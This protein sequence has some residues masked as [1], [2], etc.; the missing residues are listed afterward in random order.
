ML[1]AIFP[2]LV[3]TMLSNELNKLNGADAYAGV[4]LC[5]TSTGARIQTPGLWQHH[6]G[7]PWDNR[8]RTVVYHQTMAILQQKPPYPT[9]LEIDAFSWDKAAD[10]DPKNTLSIRIFCV[11]R[12]YVWA[13]YSDFR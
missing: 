13:Y 4:Q 2:H 11:P 3:G 10:Y 9:K 7:G 6:R 5:S 12:S 8:L 1:K